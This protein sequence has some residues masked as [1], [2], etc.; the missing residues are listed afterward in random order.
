MSDLACITCHFNFADFKRPVGILE[1]SDQAPQY[2]KDNL[3]DFFKEREED[4][5]SD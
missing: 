3:F 1:W 4:E 2:L 5:I